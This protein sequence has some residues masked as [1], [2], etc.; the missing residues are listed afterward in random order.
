MKIAKIINAVVCMV[1]LFL[2]GWLFGGYGIGN[3]I[4]I[5]IG[6]VLVA[7]MYSI[8]VECEEDEEGFES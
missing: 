6:I 7:T 4:S 8:L 1:L 2:S 5:L 3:I